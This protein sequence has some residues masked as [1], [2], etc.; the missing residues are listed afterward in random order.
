MIVA[1]PRS[2]EAS[3]VASQTVSTKSS[4]SSEVRILGECNHLSSRLRTQALQ[5]A[6]VHPFDQRFAIC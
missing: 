6:R 2:E 3:T 1:E 4:M 5:M